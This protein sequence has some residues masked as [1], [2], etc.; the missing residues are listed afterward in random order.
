MTQVQVCTECGRLFPFLARGLCADCQREREERFVRVRDWLREHRGAQ[1]EEAAEACE[2]PASLV[3]EW[4]QEGRLSVAGGAP[5][6]SSTET[7]LRER[8]R[9]E[10][11]ASGG[12]P[13]TAATQ[14]PAREQP[15]RGMR[16]RPHG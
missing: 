7:A 14:E 12:V 9:R 1:L 15:R 6:E 5:A 8:L 2:V 10:L 3:Q 13:Q 16:S 11:L 4:V